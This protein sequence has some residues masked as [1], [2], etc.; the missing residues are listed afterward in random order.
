MNSLIQAVADAGIIQPL[1]NILTDGVCTKIIIHKRINYLRFLGR[2]QVAKGSNNS[3][4]DSRCWTAGRFIE[5]RESH[6]K[7]P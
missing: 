3:I 1:I 5:K 4:R 6:A 7:K 2:F